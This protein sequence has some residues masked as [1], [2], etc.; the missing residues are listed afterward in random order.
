M[1]IDDLQ[2]L[3]P[4]RPGGPEEGDSPHC[5]EVYER[6]ALS[7][8]A[9][10][11]PERGRSHQRVL[12]QTPAGSDP[13]HAQPKARIREY[14]PIDVNRSASMRSSMPPW[15]AGSRPVSFTFT[16]RVRAAS[17]GSP[18]GATITRRTPTL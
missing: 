11:V 14:D 12:G 1:G 18:S 16:S 4:D 17:K 10:T 5:I 6:K 13:A 15:P 2:R 9:G 8:R 3:L 7:V